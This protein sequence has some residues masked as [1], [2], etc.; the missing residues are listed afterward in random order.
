MSARS[1]A[2]ENCPSASAPLA[3][4]KVVPEQLFRAPVHQRDMLLDAA[5][6][7]TRDH[8]AGFA[9]RTQHGELKHLLERKL[10]SDKYSRSVV[11]V[12]VV[13]I[14]G[15]SGERIAHAELSAFHGLHR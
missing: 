2:Q 6:N 10:F 1:S 12:D 11:I 5:G 14:I 3:L 8:I 9:R 7:D 13:I 4:T 15:L